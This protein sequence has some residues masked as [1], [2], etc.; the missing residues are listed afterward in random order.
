NAL[1]LALRSLEEGDSFNVSGFGDS[2]ETMFTKSVAYSQSTLDEASKKIAGMD[3]NLGGTEL[4]AP[5]NFLAGSRAESN[6]PR[7]IVLLT[8]GQVGNEAQCL[9]VAAKLAANAR[10]FGF[11]IGHGVSEHLVRGLSRATNG[12]AEFIHPNERIEPKVMRQF[13]RMASGALTNVRVDFGGLK[14]DLVAPAQLPQLFD[15]DRFTVYA[16]IVGGAAN[17]I[18][19]TADSPNGALRFPVKIDLEKPADDRAVPVLMA[20]KA[21]QELEEGRGG[22][23]GSAQ[24]NRKENA[25]RS[26]ILEL[27]VRYQIMSSATSFV[28]VEE[29][30]AGTQTQAAELRRVPVALTKGWGAVE[31]SCDLSLQAMP[32]MAKMKAAFPAGGAGMPPPAPRAAACAPMQAPIP[33]PSSAMKFESA[34]ESAEPAEGSMLSSITGFFGRAKSAVAGAAMPATADRAGEPADPLLKLT[35]SQRADGSFDLSASVLEASKANRKK[36]DAAIK[37]LGGDKAQAERITSTLLALAVLE[38]DFAD[39]RDEWKMIADKAERWL[40]KQKLPAGAADWKSW[41]KSAL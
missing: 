36:I 17:E 21:I 37:Q 2:Y 40:S 28:A 3:A 8:D 16:R 15:G 14:T 27:A 24:S 33:A 26:R 20:R 5:L 25:T 13:S 32:R 6:L 1:L 39:R 7:Q 9:E 11:G 23:L 34:S 22:L 18:A 41:A 19:I 35:S 31:E 29:R 12:Q 4:L 30:Q 38:R 10:I